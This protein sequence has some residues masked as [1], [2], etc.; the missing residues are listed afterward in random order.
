MTRFL[1]H[2]LSTD[3]ILLMTYILD[4][5]QRR[6]V[7]FPKDLLTKLGLSEGDKLQI[8]VRSDSEAVIK[9]QKRV[10]LKALKEIQAIFARSGITK[11]EFARQ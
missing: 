9:P 1:T 5:K 2:R 7:T 8:E 11:N 6:Q 10:A 3:I 4:I